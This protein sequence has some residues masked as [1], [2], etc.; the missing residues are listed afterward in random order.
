MLRLA[1]TRNEVFVVDDV[2]KSDGGLVEAIDGLEILDK[3]LTFLR[4]QLKP[5]TS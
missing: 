1:L 5:M 2:S 4:L 3:L